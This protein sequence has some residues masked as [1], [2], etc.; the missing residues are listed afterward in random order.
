MAR[1]NIFNLLILDEDLDPEKYF[2]RI[3]E[4]KYL[5]CI[6]KVGDDV[7]QVGI[8]NCNLISFS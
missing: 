7:R 3:K 1:S 6:F 2:D 5:G 4:E 8:S